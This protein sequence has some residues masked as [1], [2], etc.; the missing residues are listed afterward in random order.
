MVPSTL[1]IDRRYRGVGRIKRASGTK[2]PAVKKKIER[3]LEVL[4]GQG[5]LDI[6]RALRDV[7]IDFL[8]VLDAYQ[9]NALD[10]LPVGAALAPLAKAFEDWMNSLRA[11]VDASESHIRAM[12]TTVNYLKAVDAKAPIGHAAAVLDKLNETLGAK[13]PRSFNLTRSHV[14]RFVR[15][16]LKKNHP[17]WLACAAVEPRKVPKTTKRTP[18]T[19]DQMRNFFPNPET[20]QLDGIAW[21]MA[22]T[23]MHQKELWGRWETKADRVEIQGTKRGGRRR[24]VP[25]IQA[26]TVP[27]CHRRTFEDALRSR[28]SQFTP[29]DLRRTYATWLESAGIPRTRRRL[30]MGHGVKDVTDLYEQHEVTAFLSDD[31]EKLRSFVGITASGS[32]GLKAMNSK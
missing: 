8:E 13:H 24:S 4:H 18:L 14:L 21:S 20:D 3:M 11:D 17:V 15:A 19:P 27:A 6:L 28:T 30:Y 31:G 29:Y 9:R 32:R 22:T 10:T 12:R 2:I 23:G 16:K 26:P 7:R 1:M 5:R 25:L